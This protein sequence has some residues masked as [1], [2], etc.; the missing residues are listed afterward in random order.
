MDIKR[1]VITQAVLTKNKEIY[2]GWWNKT[3]IIK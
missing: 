2:S 1:H 3:M